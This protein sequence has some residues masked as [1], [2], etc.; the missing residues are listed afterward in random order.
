MRRYAKLLNPNK[1]SLIKEFFTG[2]KSKEQST[3]LYIDWMKHLHPD[4]TFTDY[5]IVDGKIV[6]FVGKNTSKNQEMIIKGELEFWHK[7]SKYFDKKGNLK[8][9]YLKKYK[10]SWLEMSK[11]YL[12]K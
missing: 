7:Y 5:K 10:S 3:A 9:K 2:T 8:P 11:K 4:N 12:K 6:P 1:G